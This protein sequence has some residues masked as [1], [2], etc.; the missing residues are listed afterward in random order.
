MNGRYR[1]NSQ[2]WGAC[3]CLILSVGLQEPESR[4]G[5]TPSCPFRA[6]GRWEGLYDWV[7]AVILSD[8]LGPSTPF[9][10]SVSIPTTPSFLCTSA[11]CPEEKEGPVSAFKE[12]ELQ[13]LCSC[14][15]CL[16]ITCARPKRWSGLKQLVCLK[17]AMGGWVGG[18]GQH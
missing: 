3:L 16:P 7:P 9:R 17:G 15:P 10:S 14:R 8:R 18:G 4:T 5:Q 1:R 13:V 2:L 11:E 12:K 6:E